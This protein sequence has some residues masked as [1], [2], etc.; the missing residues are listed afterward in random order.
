MPAKPVKI[1]APKIR[2]MK[3]RERIVCLTAYD[4]SSAR[5]A[6]EAGVDLVLVG[7]S[8]GNV[9]FGLDTTLPVTLAD[10]IHHLAPVRRA[11]TRP[12]IVADM[13]F[14]TYGSSLA[15]AVD[16]AVELVRAGA[17]AVKLEGAFVEEI[18][19]ISKIGIPVMGH[20]G[21]TPQSVHNF[22]GFK[23]Q[24]KGS[25]GDHVLQAAK[26]IDEAGV[27]SMVLELIPSELAARIT[28]S[29]SCPTIGIGAGLHC[30]GEVQ[31]FH[32]I[33]GL[34]TF[35]PKHAK[36]YVEGHSLFTD[37]VKR[38]ADDV[39]NCKFPGDEQSS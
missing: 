11:I 35:V 36:T 8:M 6:E 30:D 37:A 17:E 32:D 2:A 10:I 25:D 23:I 5:I 24:G 9:V 16:T 28:S 13:P 33:L 21:M 39:R 4:T 3:D 29:V 20:V 7:D 38:F 19:A 15:Q 18:H 12:L 26:A 34:G 31:V 27:F 1:T 22:G 14:G